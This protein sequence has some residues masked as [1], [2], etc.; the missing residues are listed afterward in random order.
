MAYIK[1]NDINSSSLG[2]PTWLQLLPLDYLIR[3]AF[4]SVKDLLKSRV[5]Q[6]PWLYEVLD[7]EAMLELK[8]AHGRQA[9][10]KKR[11]RV[12]LKMN[13]P[14]VQRVS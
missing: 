7:Y 3:L 8:D 5:R 2:L 10:Y 6:S 1:H 14:D 11:Q 12:L 13:N 4:N 9:V